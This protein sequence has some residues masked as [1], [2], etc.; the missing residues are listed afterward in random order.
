MNGT[1]VLGNSELAW[2]CDAASGCSKDW[3]VIGAADMNYDG[4][5]DLLWYNS[6]TGEVSAWLLNGTNVTGTM[7][8]SWRCAAS[9]D[10]SHLW[11]PGAVIK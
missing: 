6:V 2:K 7:S 4:N 1:A 9:T 11:K 5:I 10:C 8:L 3:K